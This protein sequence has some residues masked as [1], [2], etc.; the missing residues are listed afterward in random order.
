MIAVAYFS[1]AASVKVAKDTTDSY[2]VQSMARDSDC[3]KETRIMEER[4]SRIE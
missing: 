3:I 4:I 1:R 2:N